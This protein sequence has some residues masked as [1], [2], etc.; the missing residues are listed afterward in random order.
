MKV[1]HT[2]KTDYIG[3]LILLLGPLGSSLI[4]FKMFCFRSVNLLVR[5]I[6]L[7]LFLIMIKIIMEV[8]IAR[9]QK[10]AERVLQ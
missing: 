1:S 7:V 5:T 8:C 4:W 3:W 2:R 9:E 10:S 6:F